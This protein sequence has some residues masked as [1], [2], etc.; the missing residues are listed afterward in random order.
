MV[1]LHFQE[2]YID[3]KLAGLK[4]MILTYQPFGPKS[5]AVLVQDLVLYIHGTLYKICQ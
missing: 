5:M 4:M 2:I 1:G 3:M